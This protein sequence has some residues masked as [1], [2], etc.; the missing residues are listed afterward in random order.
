MDHRGQVGVMER[1]EK[2]SRHVLGPKTSME[3]DLAS[4]RG[5]MR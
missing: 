4:I 5:C 2:G 3:S 1:L